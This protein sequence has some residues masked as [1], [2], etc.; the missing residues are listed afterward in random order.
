[1]NK[2]LVVGSNGYIGRHLKKIIPNLFYATREDFD[3]KNIEEIKKFLG[4]KNFE[5]CI[6]LAASIGYDK[7][8]N[9]QS[10]P[11]NT[12][13]EGLNNFLSVLD[14]KIKVIYFSSMTVY[15]KKSKSPV[16][17]SSNLLPCHS[18]GLSKVYAEKLIEYYGFTSVIIRIPGVYG[19]DRKS[20]LIYNTIKNLQN[21]KN[22]IIDTKDLEYWETI[23]IDDLLLMFKEFLNKYK[24]NSKYEFFNLSYGEEID[25]IDTVYYLKKLLNS[26]SFIDIKKGYNKLFLSNKKILKIVNNPILYKDRLKLYIKEIV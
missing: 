21:N 15:D 14:K 8:I 5:T 6:I 13:L 24:F 19:G 18:Y 7:E 9:F 12:N 3:L 26:S 10:E 2:I 20:G 16:I 25:I 23:N 1:M 22:I 17:E 4:N 11:F